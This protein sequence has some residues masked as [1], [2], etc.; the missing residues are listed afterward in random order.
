MVVGC[1]ADEKTKE[2]EDDITKESE[3]GKEMSVNLELTDRQK[4]IA[5][6]E[7][8]PQNIHDMDTAQETTIFEVE[9]AFQY[10]E[11]KYPDDTFEFCGIHNR[12]EDVFDYTETALL[13][14]SEKLGDI[15]TVEVWV[16]YDSEKK[17][18]VFFDNYEVI[19]AME[20]YKNDIIGCIKERKP[21]VEIKTYVENEKTI[22]EGENINTADWIEDVVL[23]VVFLFFSYLCQTKQWLRWNTTANHISSSM[24]VRRTTTLLTPFTT[25]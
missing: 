24:Y 25:Q 15:G 7:G 21:E 3:G 9:K 17:R 10:I 8:W 5:Q 14:K 16:S 6:I 4:E 22:P 12:F 11:K 18:Y 19:I 1:K 13:V 23:F 20:Q 2:S